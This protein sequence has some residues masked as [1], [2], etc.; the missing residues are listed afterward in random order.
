[1]TTAYRPAP[2]VP[3]GMPASTWA[4]ISKLSTTPT[5]RHPLGMRDAVM[6]RS[7]I[8]HYDAGLDWLEADERALAEEAGVATQAKLGGVG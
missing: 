6:E 7:C 8:L 4:R 5:A 1:M 3:E 2:S